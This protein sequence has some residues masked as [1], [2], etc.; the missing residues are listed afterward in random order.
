MDVLLEGNIISRHEFAQKLEAKG[1]EITVR[2]E[3]KDYEYL[4]IRSPE[5]KKRC[6]FKRQRL[7]TSVCHSTKSSKVKATG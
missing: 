6:K 3:G 2:N 4:N 5:Q 7:S 1:F